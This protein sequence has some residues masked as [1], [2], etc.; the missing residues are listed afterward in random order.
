MRIRCI[1]GEPSDEQIERLG[2]SYQRGRTIFPVDV[3]QE[4]EALGLSFW[5][6]V[7]WVEIAMQSEVVVSVP[8]FMFEVIDDRVPTVWRVRQ[9]DDGGLSL[10]PACFYDEFFHDRLSNRD[11]KYL[12]AFREL[13]NE[14]RRESAQED[15]WE[16]Y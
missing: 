6:S 15:S 2:D 5:D 11:P 4:Y 7:A 9:H 8:L 3:G 14:L 10:W 12:S 16:H 13:L 1:A